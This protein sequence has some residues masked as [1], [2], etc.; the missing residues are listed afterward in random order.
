MTTGFFTA[1]RAMGANQRALRACRRG[2]AALEF[3]LVAP[4]LFT[5]TLG[6][7][8]YGFVFYGYSVVQYGANN[9]A[10]SVAVNTM[11]IANAPAAVKAYM[12]GWIPASNLTVTAQKSNTADPSRSDIQVRVVYAPIHVFTNV[13]PLTMTADVAVKQELPYA[14]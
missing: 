6:I 9:V 13:F 4:L 5:M 8:E 12:P 3:A 10:R 11:D 1:I 14:N 2:A 7:I